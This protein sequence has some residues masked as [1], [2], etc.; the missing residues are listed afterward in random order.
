[1]DKKKIVAIS[2][3]AAGIAHTYMA[4]EKLIEGA[5]KLGYDIKVETRGAI[6]ENVLSQDDINNADMVIIAADVDIDLLQFISKKVWV[7]DT[8]AAIKDPEQV[9]NDAFKLAKIHYGK[10]S[11][12][13]NIRLGSEKKTKYSKYIMTAIGFMVP[14]TIAGGLLMAVP[15]ALAITPD[16][17]WEFPNKF[18][19]AL[20]QFGQIGLRLM[21]PILAMFLANAIGGKSAMPAG[22]LGG[23]FITDSSYMSSYSPIPLPPGISADA[24]NAGFLGALVVGFVAGYL[25]EGLKWVNWPK[26]LK[27][28]IGLM[29]IP[30]LSSFAM[31]VIVVYVIGGPLTWLVSQLYVFLNSL[32]G[33]AAWANI[34][35]G[36]LFS[37]L[38]CV[39]LGGPI[40]KTAMVVAGAIFSDT[41][42]QGNP[43]FIPNTACQIAISIPPLAMW[44]A[45]TVFPYK[46]ST[47]LK[48][49]GKAALPM[50]LVGIS[51][52]AL[53]FAFQS[54]LKVISSCMVGAMFAGGISALA[55]FNFYGGLGS[56]L[57][58]WIGIIGNS[59]FGFFWFLTVA[60]GALIAGLMFGLLTTVDPKIIIEHKL[61]KANAKA[62]H[63]DLGLFTPLAVFKYN[64]KKESK[65]FMKNLKTSAHP[66]NWFVRP[67]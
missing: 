12:S 45:T 49:S 57:G 39:D 53:P 6:T 44:I 56:P 22:L 52:G 32:S 46:Y 58:A 62:L 1:M 60:A 23:F 47:Q 19:Q 26:S 36:M 28:V 64:V 51:E 8:N 29:I 27:S 55:N 43:N 33:S 63:A 15:N 2:S 5:T 11:K 65:V 25:V 13:G 48:A 34:L 21:G 7:V 41:L 38:I 4:K 17:G 3:C 40:N 14:I 66:K 59:G 24:A 37:A 20:W 10:G 16:G 30:V 31:F 54:P 67:E 42:L 18:S 9:I 50:G 35:I 61:A